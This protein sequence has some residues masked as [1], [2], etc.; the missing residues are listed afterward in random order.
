MTVVFLIVIG[1]EASLLF[2]FLWQ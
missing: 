2:Q 1:Y